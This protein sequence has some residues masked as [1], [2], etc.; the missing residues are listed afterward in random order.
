MRDALWW[1][2]ETA[3][4]A[5]WIDALDVVLL[6]VI[7]Y[8]AVAV[9]QGTRAIQSLVGLTLLGALYG[10]AYLSGL[11]AVHWVLDN[12]FVYVVIALLILFQEDI[13]RALARAGGLL[14]QGAG[15]SVRTE[16]SVMEEVIKACFALAHRR[17]GA[18]IVIERTGALSAYTEG[19]HPIDAVVSTELLQSLFHPASPLH[20]G[21]VVVA[22]GR[23]VAAGV[24]LPISLS[25]QLSK[26]LGTRH[27]AAIGITEE[28]DG[29][30]LVVSEE[31]GTVAL[32]S[33][34]EITPVVDGNDLRQLLLERLGEPSAVEVA[35]A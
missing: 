30:C 2:A 19:G 22:R 13:R 34:G 7:L 25:K 21:A 29:L 11:A 6:A 15:G 23:I 26:T 32:V 35:H 24:F 9:M 8:R 31:R 16:A 1:V 27:R 5:S 20:D 18:L 33:R 3:R 12:L 10:V 14:G 4:G 28:T 17:I